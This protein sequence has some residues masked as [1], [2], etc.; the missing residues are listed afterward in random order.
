M[1]IISSVLLIGASVLSVSSQTTTAPPASTPTLGNSPLPLTQYSF[2]Y[3][4][5]PEQ[6]NPFPVGRGPQSG[7]NIC[8]STTEGSKSLCQTMFLNSIEDF[9]LWGSPKPNGV[10]G[11][12]EAEVVAYCSKPGHGTRIMPPGTL[13]AVQFIQT[14]GYIQVTGL[15]NQTGIGLKASDSGGELDPHGADKAGN[16]LGGLLFS[17]NLPGA[18]NNTITQVKNWSNFVGSNQ[19]CFK[20]C[21][22]KI[23]SPDYCLN[24]YDVEGCD[25]NMPASYKPNEFSV[26]LGDNQNP[27]GGDPV[28]PATSS[29][30]TYSSTDLYPNTATTSTTATGSVS[31]S[32]SGSGVTATS[33]KA[34]SAS[35]DA[36]PA[37]GMPGFGL[38][39]FYVSTIVGAMVGVVAVL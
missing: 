22:N 16:P 10:V 36:S 33:T 24:I 34:S 2:T 13:T 1:A 28:I 32:A 9:C 38:F 6:V 15:F 30:T 11:D 39:A 4:N 25:F 23:T 21:N 29:C 17:N 7:Y 27:P 5:L 14:P 12:V 8:N 20:A 31:G 18:K 35:S 19:F 3:P 26:C 37:I